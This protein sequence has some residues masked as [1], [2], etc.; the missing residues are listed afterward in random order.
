[1]WTATGSERGRG[2][3]SR[4]GGNEG[5]C[6]GVRWCGVVGQDLE[7]GECSRPAAMATSAIHTVRAKA[8]LLESRPIA[9]DELQFMSGIS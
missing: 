8:P 3:G 7:R 5:R 2:A 4:R 1:M 9:A 6:S